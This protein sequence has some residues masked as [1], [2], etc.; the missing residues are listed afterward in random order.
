MENLKYNPMI[1]LGIHWNIIIQEATKIF[2]LLNPV[3][4]NHLN[5][6]LSK[7]LSWIIRA[8]FHGHH[9]NELGPFTTFWPPSLYNLSCL[10]PFSN[11]LVEPLLHHGVRQA[12]DW[13]KPVG[14]WALCFLWRRHTKPAAAAQGPASSL[15]KLLLLLLVVLPGGGGSH[16]LTWTG[17]L[18]RKKHVQE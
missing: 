9:Y 7:I 3:C 6:G 2:R 1:F 13:C 15:L 12:W 17:K 4:H 11:H 16:S 14:V 10:L 5:H 8:L 18:W